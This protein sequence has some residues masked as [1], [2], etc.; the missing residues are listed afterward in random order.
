M[1]PALIP[2]GQGP[3]KGVVTMLAVLLLLQTDNWFGY[4]Y[5]GDPGIATGYGRLSFSVGLTRADGWLVD[6]SAQYNRLIALRPFP[7]AL[8]GVVQVNWS[9]S[10]PGNWWIGTG[11]VRTGPNG[12]R[13]VNFE[14]PGGPIEW[15]LEPEQ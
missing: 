9:S 13:I 1:G 3:T 14:G 2:P 15:I 7:G 8:P 11:N 10:Y 4:S 6:N 5:S 12:Y